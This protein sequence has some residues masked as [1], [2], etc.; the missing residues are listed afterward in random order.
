MNI[1]EIPNF[2]D[3]TI[4]SKDPHGRDRDAWPIF[5][6][7]NAQALIDHVDNMLAFYE[8]KHLQAVLCFYMHPWEFDPD[9]TKIKL[10]RIAKWRHYYRIKHNMKKLEKLLSQFEWTN[11]VG[12]LDNTTLLI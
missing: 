2:A 3:M 11:F 9:Q 8:Q 12:L 6:T 1:V 5:R 7:E 4:V 10:N